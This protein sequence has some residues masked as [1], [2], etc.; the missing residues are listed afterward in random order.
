[1]PRSPRFEGD[2]LV[3]GLAKFNHFFS[4]LPVLHMEPD[5][6]HDSASNARA[7]PEPTRS[8]AAR[9]R[10]FQEPLTKYYELTEAAANDPE[11]CRF[12]VLRP[13]AGR[14]PLATLD[15]LQEYYVEFSIIP[16]IGDRIPLGLH[17]SG[18]GDLKMGAA[19]GCDS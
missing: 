12:E 4:M 19:T 18:I 10:V 14:T 9:S 15:I 5:S 6:S 8:G 7:T 3:L 11:Y 16:V 1:V 13:P 2:A 17:I